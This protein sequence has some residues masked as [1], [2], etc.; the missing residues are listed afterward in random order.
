MAARPYAGHVRFSS[1]VSSDPVSLT[2]IDV[3]PMGAPRPGSGNFYLDLPAA[4]DPDLNQI[5][6]QWGVTGTRERIK[7]RKFYWHSDPVQQARTWQAQGVRITPRHLASPEQLARPEPGMTRKA[8]LVP[9]GTTFT[10]T[11]R[12]TNVTP[13]MLKLLLAAVDPG[14]YL[15]SQTRRPGAA[16]AV[17]LGG[18]RPLGLGSATVTARLVDIDEARSRYVAG[19]EPKDTDEQETRLRT[20]GPA[21]RVDPGS[22]A[23][24]RLLDLNGL[25]D[26]AANVHY[27]P[28]TTWDGARE[29]VFRESFRFF[30]LANGQKLQRG[31]RA[32][33]RLPTVTA[34]NDVTLP[35]E[36]P[37]TRR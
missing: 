11:I 2:S 30:Q 4:P 6:S 12:A 32:W 19:S 36:K 13:I 37:R 27:P 25:G 34:E 23:L 1:A 22:E 18:G 9:A 35:I 14:D 16:Y 24:A 33:H 17:H 29:R 20:W 28:G 26:W 10:A 7:G 31:S 15:Q 3:A 8:D 5:P 21:E